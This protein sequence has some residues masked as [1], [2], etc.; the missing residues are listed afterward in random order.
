MSIVFNGRKKFIIDKTLISDKTLVCKSKGEIDYFVTLLNKMCVDLIEIDR[1]SVAKVNTKRNSANF[2][3]VIKDE[4]DI[5]FINDYDFKY[6]VVDI[7]TARTFYN[8]SINIMNKSRIILEIDIKDLNMIFSAV[9]YEIF[10]NFNVFCVRVKNVKKCNFNG[11]CNII[12]KIKNELGV[13]VDFCAEDDYY[14]ATAV[15]FEACSDGADFI[16]AAFNGNEYKL[17]SLEEV[18]LALKIINNAE[19]VGD[20]AILKVISEVYEKLTNRKISIIKPV[21]GQDIFKCESGIHVNGIEKKSLTYE[22]YKPEEIGMKR[23][24][25]IGKHSGS[26]AVEIKLKQLNI[27]SEDIDINKFLSL[28]REKSIELHRN[29]FDDEL[30]NM[31]K[32]FK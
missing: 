5:T 10:N 26:K 20:L 13:L 12:R 9:N 1:T 15:A 11:W 8:S 22:P 14:M 27:R 32:N 3:Y 2:A 24:I 19:I 17:A 28:I 30:K 7:K 16:T 23:E 21:I 4:Q 25:I 31:Y 18:I 6:L 29:I